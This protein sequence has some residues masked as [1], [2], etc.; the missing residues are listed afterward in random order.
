[1]VNN[2]PQEFS[3]RL[4]QLMLEYVIKHIPTGFPTYFDDFLGSLS[5]LFELLDK[6]ALEHKDAQEKNKKPG[7]RKKLPRS[8]S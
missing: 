3:N 2:P 8:A 1:M 6:A 4:R 5:E 7:E